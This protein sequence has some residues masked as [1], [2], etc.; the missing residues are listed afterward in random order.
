MDK[1]EIQK[2]YKTKIKLINKYNYY[3]FDKNNPLVKDSEYDEIKKEILLLE[4]QYKFLVS[5]RSPSKILGHKPSK[6]FKKA[7][8]R[9][10]MLSLSNAFSE[11]DLNNFEKRILNYLSEDKNFKISY[12]AEP[13]IDGISASLIYKNGVLTKGLSRGDGK[14]GEDITDN[15]KTIKDIPKLI[16]SKNFPNEIDIRG[17]VFIQNSD[18]ENIKEKFANPRN[19][20]SGS[21]R[22]KNPED[23][24]KIPLKFIAYTFGF[25]KGLIIDNQSDYLNQ[26][27]NWGFKTN[28]LNKLIIG[29]KNLIKNYNEVEKKRA[30]LDFDIDGI[31]YKINDFKLQKF[32]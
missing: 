2:K 16:K 5:K 6:N 22:Q 8:H 30:N 4:K 20:A 25:E 21:L 24:K 9:V 31:V 27:S 13:K 28:P 18:F 17:E 29:I 1:K 10:P 11:E 14:E 3:Y 26:L 15:L 12:S 32:F 23:T 19:A 7:K